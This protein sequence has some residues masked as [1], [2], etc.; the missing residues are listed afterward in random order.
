MQPLLQ[1][2]LG[3]FA[4]GLHVGFDVDLGKQAL[5]QGL[6]VLVATVQIH[7]TNDRF[8]GIG[9]DR[10]TVLTARAHLALTQSHH[11]RQIQVFG[12]LVQ[13]VLFD[14][15]GP[16]PRQIA[17]GQISQ[18]G[19]QHV[20]DREVEHRITQKLQALVVVGA[21]AAVRDRLLQQSMLAKGV[22]Q[23]YLQF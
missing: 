15:V 1:F 21:E 12:Q 9:Q 20:R 10:R 7:R 11:G 13:G 4:H 5:D 8:Q 22:A 16:H 14:Q 18:L 23:P 19:V 2:G 3:V 17:F 6:R